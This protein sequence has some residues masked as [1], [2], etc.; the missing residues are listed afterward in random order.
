M[1]ARESRGGGRPCGASLVVRNKDRKTK[2]NREEIMK[3]ETAEK[4]EQNENVYVDAEAEMYNRDSRDAEYGWDAIPQ[5][6]IT[7][8]EGK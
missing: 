7:R 1:F 5:E 3:K 6:W 2:N 8:A 4:I